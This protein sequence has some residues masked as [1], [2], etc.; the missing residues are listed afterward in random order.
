M[1][2]YLMDVVENPTSTNYFNFALKMHQNL[3]H[4]RPF[5]LD[6]IEFYVDQ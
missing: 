1:N 2:A 3:L 5:Y 6:S 4:V